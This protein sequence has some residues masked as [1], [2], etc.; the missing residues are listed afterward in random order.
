MSNPPNSRYSFGNFIF[1]LGSSIKNYSH[2]FNCWAKGITVKEPKII[3]F[4]V[5]SVAESK[6]Y[7]Q[8]PFFKIHWSWPVWARCFFYLFWI[9]RSFQKKISRTWRGWIWISDP[10]IFSF[11]LEL[12]IDQKEFFHLWRLHIA[13]SEAEICKAT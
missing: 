7:C 11:R 3:I 5:F 12:R 2:F 9:S 8:N 13:M 1:H 4:F 10:V 6:G